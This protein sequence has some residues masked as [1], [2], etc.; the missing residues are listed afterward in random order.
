[1]LDGDLDSEIRD[2]V[3]SREEKKGLFW[4]CG[5]CRLYLG[6]KQVVQASVFFG[7]LVRLRLFGG[8]CHVTLLLPS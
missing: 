5:I 2:V 3:L 4:R 6:G 7:R 8:K 1:M